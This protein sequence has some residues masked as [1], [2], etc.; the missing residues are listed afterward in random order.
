MNRH[1]E[2]IGTKIK[3]MDRNILPID[4]R[5]EF[6]NL[7]FLWGNLF[8][9]LGEY[10]INQTDD[11]KNNLIVFIREFG[12]NLIQS[13][14]SLDDSIHLVYLTRY[15]IMDLLE[16]QVLQQKISM[17]NYFEVMKIIEYIYQLISKTLL[18]IYNE[19]MSFIQ[20][21]L[22]ESREDLKMTLK[23]LADLETV[24]NEATI[25]AISDREDKILYANDKFC[26]LYQY[27]KEELIG[28]KHDLYSSNYHPPAFFDEIWETIDRGEAWKGVILNQA[29]DGTQYWLDTTIIPFVDSDGQRYKHISIQ[30]D[31][32][33][34][35][36]SEETL[37]KAEKLSAIGELAAGIAHEIRNP[38]TTIRGF[39]QLMNQ[40]VMEPYYATTILDEI[41]RINF[42]VSE[43]MVFS[44]PHQ[45][46]FSGCHIN[47]IIV[48]VVKFL[49]PEAILKN[50]KIECQLPIEEVVI[51]GE[52]N[53][54]KQVFLNLLKNS[55]EAMPA[56]GN[57]IILVERDSQ[58][59]NIVITIK[60]DGIGMDP[61]QVKKLG[62]PFFTSKQDGNGLGLMVSYKIIQNHK[63]SIRV[64][65]NLHQGT[66]F[67]ISFNGSRTHS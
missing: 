58:N 6:E 50:V 59:Q 42:I 16:Q 35:R 3:E 31:I 49:E 23:E 38:L 55:I 14:A 24:L 20:H 34:K 44:K 18:T 39:V 17:Q 26:S 33:E 13:K 30:Y 10:L 12:F 19:E 64:N 29:K 63:G 41:D 67:I 2:Y 8:A 43:L 5:V 7:D 28:K 21:A 9:P 48:S 40:N 4:K 27:S 53:Q 61:E 32:T 65:S 66:T 36:N 52:K 15:S 54:L 25:F 11:N 37:R 60:D 1:I 57:I 46:Q 47:S 56:G 62:E 45:V 51:A 22:D